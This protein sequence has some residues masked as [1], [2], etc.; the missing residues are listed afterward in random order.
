MLT[1][2]NREGVQKVLV[3]RD[4]LAQTVQMLDLDKPAEAWEGWAIE[5]GSSFS[6]V[7]EEQ[8]RSMT[9]QGWHKVAE[10]MFSEGLLLQDG[11]SGLIDPNE[12]LT[13]MMVK[14][15]TGAP[16]IEERGWMKRLAVH[17]GLIPSFVWDAQKLEANR[18]APPSI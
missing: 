6:A 14:F 15:M 10:E 16:A 11:K 5:T 1:L 18:L 9:D 12:Q 7:M 8:A 4:H 3:G 2:T 13:L 17:A